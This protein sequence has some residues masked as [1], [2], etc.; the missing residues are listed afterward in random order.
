[1]VTMNRLKFTMK[2]SMGHV[3]FVLLVLRLVIQ[4]P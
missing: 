4:V 1:M 3:V 2:L